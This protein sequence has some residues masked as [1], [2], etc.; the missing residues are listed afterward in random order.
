VDTNALICIVEIPQGSRN[1]YGCDPELSGMKL[2]RFVSASV[3]HPTD[4]GYVPDTVAP[5]GDP[6]DPDSRSQV[7]GWASCESALKTIEKAREQFL[8]TTV[9]G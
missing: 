4:Y 3:V 9:R 6:L 5:D 1:K 2:D 8:I 7:K